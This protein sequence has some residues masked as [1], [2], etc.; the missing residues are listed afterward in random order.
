MP[1]K[2]FEDERRHSALHA[3]ELENDADKRAFVAHNFAAIQFS[4]AFGS[5]G[6]CARF[7]RVCLLASECGTIVT[8]DMKH[9]QNRIL[10]G[11]QI[12]FAFVT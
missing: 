12:L 8:Y 1:V 4:R 5:P 2:C 9:Y 6:E 10:F 3:S 11:C 7:R